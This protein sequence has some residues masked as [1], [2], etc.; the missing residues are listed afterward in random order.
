MRWSKVG[1]CSINGSGKPL[2][3]C[4]IPPELFTKCSEMECEIYK[5]AMA[6]RLPEG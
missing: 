5:E 4:P 2:F 1:W 3:Q 6:K